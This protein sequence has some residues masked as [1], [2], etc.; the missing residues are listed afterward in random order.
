MLQALRNAGPEAVL[1]WQMAILLAAIV[2]V[3]LAAHRLRISPTVGYLLL[4]LFLGPQSLGLI[5]SAPAVHAAGDL[6]IAFLLFTIGLEF[7]L[8]RL[9]VLARDVFRLGGLQ[10]AL[11]GAV[12]AAAAH[13]WGLAPRAAILIG[14]GLALSS[15]TI[16]MSVLHG[17]REEATPLGRT[18][19]AVLL[20]QD[21]AAVPLLVLASLRD[22]GAPMIELLSYALGTAGIAVLGILVFGRVVLR[23]L[24][25][26]AGALRSSELFLATTLLAVVAAATVADAAGLSGAIG[27]F[28]A[29]LLL[30]ETEH[31]YRIEIDLEPFRGV[32]IGVFFITVGMG[33]APRT[34]MQNAG[35]IALVLPI[36]VAAKATV[37]AVLCRLTGHTWDSAARTGSLL[38]GA[39]EFSLVLFGT[40]I[41]TGLI[42]RDIGQ[43]LIAA[44]AISML[45]TPMFDIGG[46][47][48][49]RLI[50]SPPRV[51][52]RTGGSDEAASLEEHVVIIGFSRVGKS[53]AELLRQR[54]LEVVG[55]D[56]RA[57]RVAEARRDGFP[58]VCGDAR[59]H[60]LLD[61]LHL[62]RAL[63]AI[64][65][66]GDPRAVQ[67]VVSE[68]GRH[69]P[70][71]P[72]IVR[73]RDDAI[74]A[75]PERSRIVA[76]PEAEASAVAL[77]T[78]LTNLL[79]GGQTMGNDRPHQEPAAALHQ[80]S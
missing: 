8:Q 57:Q 14:F 18:G 15:T 7:S 10:V 79:E 31:R 38:A 58:V 17:R 62:D 68:L 36:M 41:E 35:R 12:L 56:L 37:L 72:V 3:L 54:R 48:L 20:F 45:L 4:G 60:A 71:L 66:I 63:A 5:V 65:A 61:R 2:G 21:L 32:L 40:G 30:A 19:L 44:A 11:T 78:A 23:P 9:R 52:E 6:G 67:A 55:V 74:G 26:Q 50:T 1:L 43:P 47:R 25:I 28:L 16:V 49:A 77:A 13:A 34:L 33:V 69:A 76:I 39:G 46:R 24:F 75:W 42:P 64:I 51:S 29:G 70:D 80:G 22:E 59:R 73:A 53:V 27:A